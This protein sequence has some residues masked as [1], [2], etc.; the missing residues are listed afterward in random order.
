MKD[1]TARWLTRQ[2]VFHDCTRDYM[3]RGKPELQAAIPAH[4]TLFGTKP[5]KCLAVDNKASQRGALLL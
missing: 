5:G 2:R 3:L 4:K 1:E